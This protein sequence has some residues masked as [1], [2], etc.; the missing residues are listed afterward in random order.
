MDQYLALPTSRLLDEFGA[1]GAV[2]GSGSAAALQGCLGAKLAITVCRKSIEK[3]PAKRARF[4][5]LQNRLETSFNN[6]ARLVQED[7]AVFREVVDARM[8][9]DKEQDRDRHSMLARRA[10]DKLELTNPII[11]EIGR[12]CLA[13]AGHAQA[14]FAEGWEHVRGDSG[15]AMTAA[16][17]GAMSCVF[18]GRVNAKTLGRRQS[19][20]SILAA[21]DDLARQVEAAFAAMMECAGSLD[22][23]AKEAMGTL[24]LED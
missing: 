9:R 16:L 18:V 23:S 10:N 13:V 2:P 8:A 20:A 6:L 5:F 19:A 4:E 3:E 1:G 17:G 22:T 21:S 11:S 14:L 7:S 24:K 15:A 12:E